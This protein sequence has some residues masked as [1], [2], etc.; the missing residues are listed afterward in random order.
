MTME[1][2][3]YIIWRINESEEELRA[4][5][6]RPELYADKVKNLKPGSKRLL[7]V[8]AVRCALRALFYGEEQEVLYDERGAPSLANGPFLSISHTQGFAA[9]CVSPSPVGIDIERLGN[10][11]QR[12]VSQFLKEDEVVVLQMEANQAVLT[13]PWPLPCDAFA[14]AL[15]L[16]WSA[17][18]AIYKVLGHDYYDLKQLVSVL[19]I[20]WSIKVLWL[21]VQGWD[22]PW[23]VKFD[24]NEEYVLCIVEKKGASAEEK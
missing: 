17:K 7:E 10:R 12:V 13:R 16:A 24:C 9:V 8:L 4:Q 5:L 18:E 14:L 21:R 6:S 20:D 15:H 1:Q 11:V 3:D 19:H 23:R 22:A 2:N